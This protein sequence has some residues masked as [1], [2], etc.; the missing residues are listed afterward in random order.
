MSWFQLDRAFASRLH[1]Q[2]ASAHRRAV[3]WETKELQRWPGMLTRWL[4]RW[5][6]DSRTALG[7]A[8]ERWSKFVANNSE[9]LSFAFFAILIALTFIV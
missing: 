9:L 2:L 3:G 5:L 6:E 7:V 8:L 1:P 4:D